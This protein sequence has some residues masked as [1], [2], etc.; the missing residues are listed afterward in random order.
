MREILIISGKGGTGKTM[1]TSSFAVLARGKA[2]FADCDVDAADLFLML[3][4]EIKQT[5]RFVGGKKAAI[6]R[7]LCNGC[8][9]CVDACRFDAISK[10]FIVDRISC[11][12]CSV[13]SRVCPQNAIVME[14]AV[15][16]EWFISET[17]YGP[18]VYAK[19]GVAEE[20]SGK[21]VTVVKQN[22]KEIAKKQE[23]DFIIVDGPPGVGCPVIAALS[24][25]DTAVI[26][27]E[28]TLSG[29]QDMKRVIS[30][31]RNF[32]INVKVVINKFDLNKDLSGKI[33][34]YC[35]ENQIFLLGRIEFNKKV[36]EAVVA[37]RPVVEYITGAVRQEIV[38][39]WDRLQ[40]DMQSN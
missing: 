2:V 19:L 10:D 4:P 33:E 27:T 5:Y 23:K 37:G 18:M 30:V 25:V 39:I 11:E 36:V 7:Q 32:R 16:G 9:K 14:D 34:K 20:N 26:V 38:D 13:C 35:F 21:L 24:G 31:A 22:A 6:D 40:A 29:I 15:S 3:K 8:G 12:G 17:V 28:P 1:L